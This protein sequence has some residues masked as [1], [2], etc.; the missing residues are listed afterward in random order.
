M[1]RELHNQ[2]R[3]ISEVSDSALQ[4]TDSFVPCGSE[5]TESILYITPRFPTF[6]LACL[7]L[8]FRLSR[9]NP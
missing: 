9:P 6:S 8:L 4:I 5:G 1:K 3:K 7:A 2:S